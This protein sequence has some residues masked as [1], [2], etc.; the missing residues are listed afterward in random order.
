MKIAL[1]PLLHC[2]PRDR[3]FEFYDAAAAAP[4]DIVYLG[5]VVCSRRHELRLEDWLALAR[6]LALA[7]KEAVL[8]TQAL[9]ESESDLKLLRRIAANSNFM[10]EAND[11]GAVHLLAGKAPFVAGLHLNAYN[12]QTLALLAQWGACRWVFPLELSRDA[13]RELQQQRP[14]SLATEVFAYGRL[15]LAL[16]ARCFTARHYNASKDNCDFRCVSDPDGL[17]LSTA[18]GERFLTLNGIEVQSA[19]IHSL[20]AELAELRAL[21]VDVLRVSPQSGHTFEVIRLI[22]QCVEQS[23]SPAAAAERIATLAP[24]ATCNGYWYGRPGVEQVAPTTA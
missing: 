17:A 19:R 16:S 2:W 5:E 11:M 9:I 13:L 10:V 6:N 24:D 21:H 7:G 12:A 8:S 22:R 15:P 23:L 18:D 1:G 20:I 3:V 14:S 4:V